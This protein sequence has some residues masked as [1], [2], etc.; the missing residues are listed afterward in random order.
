MQEDFPL[1]REFIRQKI[2]LTEKGGLP[3]ILGVIDTVK[4]MFASITGQQAEAD[5]QE[6]EELQ[7]DMVSAAEMQTEE[8]GRNYRTLN[9]NPHSWKD[10]EALNIKTYAGTDGSYY[11]SVECEELPEL[12]TGLE[13]FEDEDEAEHFARM[14]VDKILRTL[15]NKER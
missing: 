2:L 10:A 11:S 13:S 8:I 9:N 4:S 12:N 6:G 5:E 15:A 1:L 7:E 14:R 3:N